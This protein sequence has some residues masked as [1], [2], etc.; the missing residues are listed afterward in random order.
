MAMTAP[1]GV[2]GDCITATLV[3]KIEAKDDVSTAGRLERPR[4]FVPRNAQ[5]IHL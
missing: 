1:A 5:L 2:I 4:A 3:L